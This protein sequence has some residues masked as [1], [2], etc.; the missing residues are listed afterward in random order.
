MWLSCYS[1]FKPKDEVK[2]GGKYL[3]QWLTEFVFRD[4]NYIKS[5]MLMLCACLK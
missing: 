1:D 4:M 5:A 3:Y 2:H